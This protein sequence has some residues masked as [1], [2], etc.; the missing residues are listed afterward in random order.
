MEERAGTAEMSS[1]RAKELDDLRMELRRELRMY[2][3]DV[4]TPIPPRRPPTP[5][6]TRHQRFIQRFRHPQRPIHP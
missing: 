6:Q 1:F 5:H 3:D 4:R 2:G